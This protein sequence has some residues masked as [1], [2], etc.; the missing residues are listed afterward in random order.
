MSFKLVISL[1]KRNLEVYSCTLIPQC[2]QR[3]DICL[4]NYL[5]IV[6]LSIQSLVLITHN[7]QPISQFQIIIHLKAII[8]HIFIE[9]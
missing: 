1:V 7:P 9:N 3:L 2:S 5:L 6:T 8:S 4:F